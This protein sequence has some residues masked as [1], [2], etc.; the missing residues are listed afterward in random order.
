MIIGKFGPKSMIFY[1]GRKDKKICWQNVRNPTTKRKCTAEPRSALCFEVRFTTYELRILKCVERPVA[2][3][4]A[5]WEN[6]G[7]GFFGLERIL[8]R[9]TPRRRD[10]KYSRCVVAAWRETKN[11]GI[12]RQDFRIDRI[13]KI[14][15]KTWRMLFLRRFTQI[16]P[17]ITQILRRSAGKFA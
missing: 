14:Y 6:G 3:S 7:Y 10:E 11:R 2:C 1:W 13:F 16:F 5:W 15:V 8:F 17:Q 9:A 4:V 12:F